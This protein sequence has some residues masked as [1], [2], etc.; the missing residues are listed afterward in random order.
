MEQTDTSAV[1]AS[2]LYSVTPEF[3]LSLRHTGKALPQLP[4]DTAV[5]VDL[6]EDD[7]GLES[8]L[9]TVEQ[10]WISLP[11]ISREPIR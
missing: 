3:L 5:V 11:I 2:S 9:R 1:F 4:L 6:P 10:S 7:E 8:M